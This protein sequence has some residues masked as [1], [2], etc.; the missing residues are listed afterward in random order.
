MKKQLLTGLLL[1]SFSG[2]AFAHPGHGEHGLVLGFMHPL[3]GI[4]HLLVMLAVGLWA[5]KLGGAAKWQLP[6]A[7]LMLMGVGAMLGLSGIVLPG[8]ETG[9]AASVMAMGLL[10]VVHVPIRQPMQIGLVALFALLHGLAHGAELSAGAG[11]ATM[12][13]MLC[14]TA[15]LHLAGLLV[16]MRLT[17]RLPAIYP[18]AGTGMML[19]GLGLLVS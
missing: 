4:D 8:L 18:V 14:A 6:L 2:V 17:G 12:T 19:V 9:I 16:S 13:G 3:T 1:A 5:G 7:F 15:L 10:L 11:L